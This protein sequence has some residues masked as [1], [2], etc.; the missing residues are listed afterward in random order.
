VEDQ[1][2]MPGTNPSTP[3]AGNTRDTAVAAFRIGI[4]VML[5]AL[6]CDMQRPSSCVRGAAEGSG[7]DVRAMGPARVVPSQEVDMP[8]QRNDQ[9]VDP[10]KGRRQHGPGDPRPGDRDDVPQRSA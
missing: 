3:T 7:G 10:V 6:V 5:F 2:L 8:G 9:K 1:D 4:A